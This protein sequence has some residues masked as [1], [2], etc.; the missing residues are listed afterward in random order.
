MV[1]SI[2]TMKISYQNFADTSREITPVL[3]SI[4]LNPYTNN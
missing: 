2:I 1:K 4:S 3:V